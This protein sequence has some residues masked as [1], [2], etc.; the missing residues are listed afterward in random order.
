MVSPDNINSLL[1]GDW[2]FTD[3]SICVRKVSGFTVTTIYGKL[4]ICDTLDP[5]I[6]GSENFTNFSLSGK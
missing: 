1:S 4:Y 5:F 3:N 6:L 2:M